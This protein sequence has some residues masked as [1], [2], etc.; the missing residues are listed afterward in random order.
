M[1]NEM[2]AMEYILWFQSDTQEQKKISSAAY[3]EVHTI[4]SLNPRM[5]RAKKNSIQRDLWE[6]VIGNCC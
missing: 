4:G 1:F 5:Q 6:I 3:F 2:K